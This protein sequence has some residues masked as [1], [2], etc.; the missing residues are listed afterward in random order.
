VKS[1]GEEDK[2]TA[3]PCSS[4]RL[5]PETRNGFC[6]R[7]EFLLTPMCFHAAAMAAI[8]AVRRE[9]ALKG[10]ITFFSLWDWIMS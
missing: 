9:V 10:L 2:A 4:P 6:L 7:E 8:T 1:T 3:A 5:Q